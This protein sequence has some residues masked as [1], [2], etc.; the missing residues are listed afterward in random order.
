MNE[1]EIKR[2]WDYT[3]FK[4]LTGNRVVTEKR[5]NKIVDSIQ[6]VGYIMN[7]IIV[8]QNY[9]VIDGQ[10]RLE[11]LKRLHRPIYYIVVEGAGFQE[12]VS[13]NINLT[14]WSVQD[15]IDSYIIQGNPYY[16]KLAK[17]TNLYKC[18]YKTV[19]FAL[20]NKSRLPSAIIKE[21]ALEFTDEDYERAEEKLAFLASITGI[22][23]LN[24][25]ISYFHQAI[26]YCYQHPLVDH[27]RLKEKIEECYTFMLP[28]KD[29]QTAVESIEAIYNR[30]LSPEKKVFLGSDFRKLMLLN[31]RQN[32]KSYKK[33]K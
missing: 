22:K 25:G 5:I 32:L 12:C 15:Y 4:K 9:E 3:L 13:M 19:C 7:P 29:A 1:Y 21:G 28:W 11:A 31:A 18:S 23:K 14:N 10:A 2:T 20:T 30:G 16:I 26:I 6:R 8:N 17:L 33:D 27:N 24:G